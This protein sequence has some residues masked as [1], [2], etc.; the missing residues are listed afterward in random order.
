MLEF[1]FAQRV[2]GATEIPRVAGFGAHRHLHSSGT[3]A[4][5]AGLP[6]IVAS[7]AAA[8]RV[9][10]LRPQVAAIAE[11]CAG[12]G[13]GHGDLSAGSGGWCAAPAIAP[14]CRAEAEGQSQATGSSGPHRSIRKD[15]VPLRVRRKVSCYL[16]AGSRVPWGRAC[17]VGAECSGKVKIRSYAGNR[18]PI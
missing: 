15:A 9:H 10:E 12:S 13:T 4:L 3:R 6:V 17:S 16:P 7:I 8:A 11:G 18:I 5:S 1:L 14:W 2:A